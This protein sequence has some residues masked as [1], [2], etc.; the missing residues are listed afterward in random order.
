MTALLI[1]LM[2]VLLFVLILSLRLKLYIRLDDTLYVS[3]GLGPVLLS[4]LPRRYKRK[5]I[6]LEDFSYEKHQK[7]L[8]HEQK[9]AQKKI[10][11]SNKK[12]FLKTLD[13]AD[14]TVK[15]EA[16]GKKTSKLSLDAIIEII[17]FILDEFPKLTASFI[18]EIRMLEINVAG[19]DASDCA[20]KYGIISQSVAYLVEIL[21]S[22]TRMKP[23]KQNAIVVKSD[24]LKEKNSYK[25]DIRLKVSLF[26]LLKSGVRSLVWLIKSDIIKI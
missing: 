19:R 8:K 17:C 16:E 4:L 18:T 9:I 1:I 21:D 2:I 24:F 15:S 11:K 14:K 26:S 20:V 3:A 13:D 7:R 25:I 22:S 10:E 5:S 6:N 12:K 23:L